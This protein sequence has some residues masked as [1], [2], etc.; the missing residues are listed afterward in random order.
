MVSQAKFAVTC[1]V[2]CPVLSHLQREAPRGAPTAA[3]C[4]SWKLADGRS[5][6]WLLFGGEPSAALVSL[7]L[8]L[9]EVS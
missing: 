1:C 2:R 6:L 4:A 9:S 8:S 7:A 5:S 3:V